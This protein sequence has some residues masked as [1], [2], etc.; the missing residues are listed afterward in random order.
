MERKSQSKCVQCRREGKKLFLRG[1][2]CNS[3]K[4]PMVKRNFVPGVHGKTS[5]RRLTDYGERFRAKQQCKKMYV[6]RESMFEKYFKKAQQTSGN[7][8]D[9]LLVLLEKRLDNTVFAGNIFPSRAM[10]RQI[11]SHKLVYVNG[12]RVDV[13]SYEV[14]V[15]DVIT[16]KLTDKMVKKLEE[17]AKTK[18][19]VIENEH[20]YYDENKKELKVLR[21]P[22]VTNIK[23]NIEVKLIVE[24][25]SK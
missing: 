8:G 16:F 17:Y 14:K 5:G 6:L 12:K 18:K 19:N 21:D 22:D 10:A 23:Q 2:K 3:P 9:N 20:V 13:P 1:E 25:Y 24:F 11:V 4:C 7:T 15:G